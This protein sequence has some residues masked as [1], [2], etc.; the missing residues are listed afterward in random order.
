MG[1]SPMNSTHVSG[2]GAAM[3]KMGFS[4]RSADTDDEDDDGDED[5][6]GDGDEDEEDLDIKSSDLIVSL[7]HSLSQQLLISLFFLYIVP[8]RV[9]AQVMA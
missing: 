8:S 2:I 4:Q 1:K 7:H 9:H 6:G 5:D 3:K